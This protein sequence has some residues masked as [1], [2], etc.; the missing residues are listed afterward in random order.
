MT[1]LRSESPLALRLAVDELRVPA[2]MALKAQKAKEQGTT[3]VAYPVLSQW[4]S[5]GAALRLEG[6]SL[7][8]G[9]HAHVLYHEKLVVTETNSALKKVTLGNEVQGKLLD[10]G[11]TMVHM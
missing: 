4:P 2:V 5:L 3:L 10:S 7:V 6:L 11:L 1:S 8:F 9:Y